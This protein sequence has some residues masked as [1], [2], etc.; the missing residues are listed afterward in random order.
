VKVFPFFPNEVIDYFGDLLKS[1]L[2]SRRDS[3]ARVNDFVDVLKDMSELCSTPEYTKLNI[4]EAT[5]MGQALFFLLAGFETTATTLTTLS[6]KLATHPEV[7][8]K[9][10]KEVDDY[11]NRHEG[12]L[13]HET[14]GELTYLQACINETLRMHAPLVRLERV[15]QKAWKDEKSG[16]EIPKGLVVQVPVYAVHY[17]EEYFPEPNKFKPER[18]LPENKEQMNPYAFLSFGQGPHNCIGMR[19]AKEEIQFA[20]ASILKDYYFQPTGDSKLTPLPGRTFLN[21]YEPFSLKLC[22]R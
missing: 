12:K 9:L 4:N 16:L 17:N 5:V 15:C 3:K 8:T 19:F 7:Q 20:M 13:E 10:L 14:I 1:I 22:K 2:K 21:N 11:Y 6:L 18:F